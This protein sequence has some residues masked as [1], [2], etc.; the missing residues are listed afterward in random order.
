MTPEPDWETPHAPYE[1]ALRDYVAGDL[2]ATL[3]IHSDLGEHDDLP[4]NIFFRES[5]DLFAFEGPALE[6][7]RGRVVD[8]GAGVGAHSLILQHHDID[9][10]AVEVLPAAVEIMRARGVHDV[11]HASFHD[12]EGG[13]FD[14]V[15][16]MMN[17]LGPTETLAGLDSFLGRVPRLMAPGGQILVDGGQA[18]L[19]VPPA[20]GTY[21]DWPPRTGDYVGEAWI[22]L[23]YQGRIAPP[24]RELY[25][26][27]DTLRRRA[28]LAGYQ[29][30]VLYEEPTS[31]TMR[32]IRCSSGSHRDDP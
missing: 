6:A 4:V 12:Y 31:Y 8:L 5:P 11:V 25:V 15:L 22:R 2:N 16:M 24:F 28:E 1:Q 26:D 7:C 18:S 23:E 20:Q 32:L 30:S 14:T 9:V 29:C 3:T 17:G 27:L 19:T 10:T 21:P 13:P